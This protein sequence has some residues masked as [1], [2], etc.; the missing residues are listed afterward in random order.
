MRNVHY[1]K[2]SDVTTMLRWALSVA[3]EN[4]T[5][6]K[7]SSKKP[8]RPVKAKAKAAKPAKA[9]EKVAAKPAAKRKA[10]APTKVKKTL[11]S[12]RTKAA[13][14]ASNPVV[15]E[16]VASTLVAAAAA[17]RNPK[18]A[19]AMAA[20]AA[21]ELH[22]MAGQAASKSGALWQLALDIARR[23]IDALGSGDGGKKPKG[24]AKAKAKKKGKK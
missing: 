23:S 21:D 9:A 12:A 2:H 3:R 11:T 4:S 7:V 14:L 18:K 17:M 19:R 1:L 20:E 6:A 8:A 16:V 22:E 13:K 24:K 10:K 15:A 5:V